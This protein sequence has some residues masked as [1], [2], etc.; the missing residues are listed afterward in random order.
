[1][2]QTEIF[3]HT[4]AGTERGNGSAKVSLEGPPSTTSNVTITTTTLVTEAAPTIYVQWEI[5]TWEAIPPGSGGSE[6]ETSTARANV[7]ITLPPGLTYT[8]NSGQ[9]LDH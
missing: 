1:L 7:R 5:V 8:S 2:L 9:F 6:T 4:V 3:A